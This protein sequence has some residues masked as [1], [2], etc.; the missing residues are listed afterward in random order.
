MH[1]RPRSPRSRA[2]LACVPALGLV[3]MAGAGTASAGRA[4][5]NTRTEPRAPLEHVLAGWHPANRAVGRH[6][7]GG[8][9]LTSAFSLNWS[10]YA[11]TSPKGSTYRS[12]TG[13]WRE[14]KITG[15]EA[16]VRSAVI[17]WVGID[18]FKSRH[19]EQDGSIAECPGNGS[20]TPVYGTWWEMYPKPLQ[21]VGM[22][23]KPGDEISASVTRK[24]TSYTLKVTDSTTKGNSLSTVKTCAVSSCPDRSAEWIAERP[25][26]AASTGKFSLLPN[27][28]TWTLASAG[29]RAGARSGTIKTFPDNQ[30]TMLDNAQRRKV[31][32][33]PGAVN[34]AGNS[35]RDTWKASS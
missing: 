31:L 10:G 33:L 12:V 25:E 13:A 23:V 18:G 17:F 2:L 29:A 15:C 19:I 14:P 27:F 3:L 1:G 22:H 5:V 28:G 21:V 35:F 9:G 4:P 24:G 26:L 11:D 30:V 7:A 34:S 16:S 20:K 8:T 32:A 6:E